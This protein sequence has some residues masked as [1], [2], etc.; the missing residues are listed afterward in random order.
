MSVTFQSSDWTGALLDYCKPRKLPNRNP[1][2]NELVKL[3]ESGEI[4]KL[5]EKSRAYLDQLAGR[6]YRCQ[7]VIFS[8]ARVRDRSTGRVLVENIP[9]RISQQGG[10]PN[11]LCVSP[12]DKGV[13]D[14]Y[15]VNT[16]ENRVLHIQLDP[17][18]DV[19]LEV[20]TSRSSLMDISRL[21]VEDIKNQPWNNSI[22]A[23]VG[24][25]FVAYPFTRVSPSQPEG[26]ADGKTASNPLNT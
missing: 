3:N 25:A 24:G 1:D 17:E 2:Y 26:L 9:I 13:L 6:T 12:P 21:A 7:A 11:T 20:P 16:I 18:S 10:V 23:N 4:D 15:L 19:E 8:E 14:F 5:A 22:V